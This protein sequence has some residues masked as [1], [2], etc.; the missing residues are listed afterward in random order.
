[1]SP[2]KI[3]ESWETIAVTALPPGWRNVYRTG[4]GTFEETQCPAI[5]LQEKRGESDGRDFYF[6]SA[7][8]PYETRAVFAAGEYCYLEAA[9]LIASYVGTIGPGETAS[10]LPDATISDT[11]V[12]PGEPTPGGT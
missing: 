3:I 4:D 6:R 8:P 11:A 10:A 5:L 7:E 1:M 9:D 2:V 12:P